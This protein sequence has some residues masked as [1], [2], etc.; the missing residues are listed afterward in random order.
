MPTHPDYATHLVRKRVL[1]V[2][3]VML[4]K[5]IARHD[6]SDEEHDNWARTV[7]VL[8]V[9]WR[10][11]ADLRNVGESWTASY[12]RQQTCIPQQ[13]RSIIFNMNVLNECR[14]AR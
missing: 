10:S 7:L 9:P 14:D 8:F 5:R 1:W 12:T 11:P 13:H 3:P 4:G 6:G 2:V